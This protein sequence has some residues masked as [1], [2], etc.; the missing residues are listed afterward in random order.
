MKKKALTLIAVAALLSLASCTKYTRCECTVYQ[1]THQGTREILTAV[2]TEYHQ[3]MEG[4]SCYRHNMTMDS[5]MTTI[6]KSAD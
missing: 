3:V 6:C 2:S 5:T 4:E 1:V